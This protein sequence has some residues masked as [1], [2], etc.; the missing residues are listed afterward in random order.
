MRCEDS[1]R[2]P[3]PCGPDSGRGDAAPSQTRSNVEYHE[4]ADAAGARPGACTV[5]SRPDKLSHPAL[6][7]VSSAIVRPL[8]GPDAYGHASRGHQA[9]A[10]A[11]P[12]H[13]PLDSTTEQTR[14]P[15]LPDAVPGLAGGRRAAPIR[16]RRRNGLLQQPLART[17]RIESQV[18]LAVSGR[19]KIGEGRQPRS[20][21]WPYMRIVTRT[22]K[23][24]CSCSCGSRNR[25]PRMRR[26]A[27]R[28]SEPKGDTRLTRRAT[29]AATTTTI[30]WRI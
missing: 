22:R 16:S 11:D 26:T 5:G 14:R 13:Q 9:N 30:E 20:K 29:V 27:K 4:Q 19:S 2:D 23:M 1:R 7:I 17:A 12:A 6:S 15:I 10:E 21:K 8:T 18:H 25:T 28:I 3:G 24:W